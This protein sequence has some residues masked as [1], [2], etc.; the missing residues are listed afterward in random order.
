M[1]K[2]FWIVI[3][4]YRTADLV[5]DCLQSLETQREVLG[6]G[7]VVVVD[8]DSGDGSVGRIAEAITAHGWSAW[9]EVVAAPRNGGFSY[10]NNVGIRLALSADPAAAWIMLLNPDTVVRSGALGALREFMAT[11]PGVG[12]AGSLL[13]NPDGSVDCSA[14]RIPSALG[15]LEGSARFGPLS[16]LLRE[17]RVSDAP[18]SEAHPCDWVSG[19]ALVMRREVL[20]QAGLMD[21]GYFLYFEEVDFCCRAKEAGW[22]VWYVPE[23]RVMHLEGA[24]TGIRKAA[25][26]RAH[27]WYDSRRRFFVRHHGVAGLILA[28]LLWALGRL[29]FLARRALRLGGKPGADPKWFMVDLLWGDLRAIM[30]GRVFALRGQAVEFPFL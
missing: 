2:N 27:Y 10:G 23:A 18:G 8:N 14:H 21:E 26:R 7:K 20:V 5:V 12:I 17:H 25:K 4:N 28:D 6:G 15:E 19:A 9:A 1:H 22:E 16:R 3:V 30:S 24:S 13:E 29:S 11:H